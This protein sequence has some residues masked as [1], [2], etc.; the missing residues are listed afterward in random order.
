MKPS[1]EFFKLFHACYPCLCNISSLHSW[2]PAKGEVGE[3]FKRKLGRGWG[4]NTN[5]SLVAPTSGRY[6]K[7]PWRQPRRFL[8]P[9]WYLGLIRLEK[10]IR[11]YSTWCSCLLK[12]LN[13]M[14]LYRK[15]QNRRKEHICGKRLYPLDWEAPPPPSCL[16]I[17]TMNE[18]LTHYKSQGNIKGQKYEHSWCFSFV[19][20]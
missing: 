14:K 19:L 16:A 12:V 2:F 5:S 17:L 6:P 10:V 13:Q 8:R 18:P 4:A 7:F 9:S 3:D 15:T 11:H 1:T 20:Y